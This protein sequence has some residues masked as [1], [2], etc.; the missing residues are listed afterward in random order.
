[1]SW[2][3]T[4]AGKWSLTFDIILPKGVELEGIIRDFLIKFG[5]YIGEYV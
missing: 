1:M 2:I 4:S 3:G 5:R